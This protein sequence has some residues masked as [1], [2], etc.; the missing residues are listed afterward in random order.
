MHVFS[1]YSYVFVSWSLLFKWRHLFMH[2]TKTNCFVDQGQLS[3]LH[4]NLCVE[5]RIEHSES[6]L[7]HKGIQQL[8]YCNNKKSND[9]SRTRSQLC[10]CD[11]DHTLS[12]KATIA[13]F[14]DCHTCSISRVIFCK[15]VLPSA[16]LAWTFIKTQISLVNSFID[17]YVW[18][19]HSDSCTTHTTASTTSKRYTVKKV[20]SL[21]TYDLRYRYM[22]ACCTKSGTN[23]N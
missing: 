10:V 6:I 5:Q 1:C 16:S 22:C 20:L 14:V 18:Q 13:S 11:D 2:F 23:L 15:L 21:S 19:P 9:Y 3:S 4:A 8:H 17:V 7:V 12:S